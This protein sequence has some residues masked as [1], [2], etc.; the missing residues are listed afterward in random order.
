MRGY[1]RD[2]GEFPAWSKAHRPLDRDLACGHTFHRSRS[3]RRWDLGVGDRP[4]ER[5]GLAD[6]LV[7]RVRQRCDATTRRRSL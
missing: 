2:T 1:A 5:D 3:H 6:R 7:A 4:P